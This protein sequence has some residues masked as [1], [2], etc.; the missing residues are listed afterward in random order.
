M[1]LSYLEE[2]PPDGRFVACLEDG[3]DPLRPA[4]PRLRSPPDDA[5]S[6]TGLL[7]VKLPAW[8][9]PAASRSTGASPINWRGC[10]RPPR[11]DTAPHREAVQ[12]AVEPSGTQDGRIR[13]RIAGDLVGVEGRHQ[14]ALRGRFLYPQDHDPDAHPRSAAASSAEG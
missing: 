1:R 12:H 8:V 6:H 3:A 11:P 4:T 5:G 13:L 7:T 10:Q 14:A 2:V 9:R